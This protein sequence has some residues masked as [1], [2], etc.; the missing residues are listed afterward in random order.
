VV[1]SVSA[2]GYEAKQQTLMVAATQL[3]EIKIDLLETKPAQP[4]HFSAVPAA[5]PEDA[6]LSDSIGATAHT[7][8]RTPLYKSPWLYVA[9]GAVTVVAVGALVLNGRESYPTA[10]ATREVPKP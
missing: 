10:N 7:S 6:N 5:P 3:A 1:V 9:L 8:E 2:T 4:A